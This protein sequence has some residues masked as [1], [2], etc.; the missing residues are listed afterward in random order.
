MKRFS[1][2]I[3]L[4]GAGAAFAGGASPALA[5]GFGNHC[6]PSGGN[7]MTIQVG[8]TCVHGIAHALTQIQTYRLN[9]TTTRHC[10]GGNET[11]SPSSYHKFGYTC[12][13]GSGANGFV[14]TPYIGYGIF[15]YPI[16]KNDGPYVGGFYSS[17]NFVQDV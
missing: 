1:A 4:L 13:I 16:H 3:A 14:V 2:A 8:D 11:T 12:G 7:T 9:N 15:S 10:A 5:D 6:P 17:F